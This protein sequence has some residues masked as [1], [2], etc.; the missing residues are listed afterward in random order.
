MT[1]V[2]KR[3]TTILTGF[4]RSLR[5]DI[6]HG[7]PRQ[8]KISNTFEPIEFEIA[9]SPF[10]FFTTI[11]LEIIS[12][13]EVPKARI[14]KPATVSGMPKDPGRASTSRGKSSSLSSSNEATDLGRLNGDWPTLS[15]SIR[16]MLSSFKSY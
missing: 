14:V 8:I 7:K 4:F 3:T 12:G 10:P 11:I 5:A 6:S 16:R 13:T 1:T 15:G 2:V 9:I